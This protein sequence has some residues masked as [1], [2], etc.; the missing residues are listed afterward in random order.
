MN[1]ENNPLASI[2]QNS[3]NMPENVVFIESRLRKIFDESQLLEFARVC[4]TVLSAGGGFGAVDVVFRA[5]RPTE[6]DGR[7]SVKLN[8]NNKMVL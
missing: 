6:I 7:F 4:E 3:K 1:S 8:Q 2:K 5:S